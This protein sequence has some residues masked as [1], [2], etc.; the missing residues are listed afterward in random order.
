MSKNNIQ[1]PLFE[2]LL[3]EVFAKS[4]ILN[5]VLLYTL[6]YKAFWGCSHPIPRLPYPGIT[7]LFIALFARPVVSAL[8]L[9]FQ[10][11]FRIPYFILY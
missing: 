1:H 9:F 5:V 4:N 10:D 2:E 7:A 11:G 3:P 6:L 8:K